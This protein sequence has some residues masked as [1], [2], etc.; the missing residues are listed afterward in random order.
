MMGRI[1]LR[2][3]FDPIAEQ[4]VR[5]ALALFSTLAARPFHIG[6]VSTA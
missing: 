1:L 4:E 5:K 3:G 6:R 2:Q